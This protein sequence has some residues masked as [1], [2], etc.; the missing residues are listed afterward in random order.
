MK[1]FNYDRLLLFLFWPLTAFILFCDSRVV[2]EQGWNGQLLGNLLAPAFLLAL[3]SQMP[4]QRRLVAAVFVPLSAIG[5]GIFSLVFGLYGYRLGGVPVYVPFGHSILLCIGLMLADSDFVMRHERRVRSTLICF[6]GGLIAGALLLF[7]DTLSAIWGIGFF[8]LLHRSRGR[9]LYLIIGVLVLYIEILGTVW[10]CWV[11]R[12]APFGVLHTTNPPTGAFACYV[13][14]E[15]IA[16]KFAVRLELLLARRRA[17]QP[18]NTYEV[19]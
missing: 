4:P 16:M 7:N 19:A 2:A 14:A 8:A 18:G 11:W 17:G 5:E 10:G 12:P 9:V 6:H 13:V 1:K 3:M 15:I